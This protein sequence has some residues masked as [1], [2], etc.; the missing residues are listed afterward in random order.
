MRILVTGG[1]GFIG[2]L[3][4]GE[5]L[6]RGTWRT[7]PITEVV[8][9]DRVVRPL[10]RRSGVPVTSIEGDLFDRAREAFRQPVDVVVH[11]AAAVSSECEADLD[12]GLRTNIGGTWTVLEEARAQR[13]A[14]GPTATFV[15]ASSVAVYGSDPEQ[16]LPAVVTD[17]TLPVPRSSYGAQKLSCEHVLADY[18]RRGLVDARVVRLMTVAVRPG[19]PNAAAS[20]FVSSIIREPLAGRPAVCPVGPDVALALASPRA[21][22]EGILTVAEADRGTRRGELN[23]L[24]PVNLPALTA[25]VGE[26]LGA[27]RRVGGEDAAALVS[28]DLDPRVD[29]IVR[30][31]PARFTSTRAAALGLHPDPDVESLIRAYVDEHAPSRPA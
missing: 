19:A 11:L 16:P 8:I 7:E 25:T 28:T 22:V 20:S 10:A 26:L 30:S 3:V 18:T 1:H 17:S 2:S 13:E 27:L 6:R 23:G 14:G 21:T 5:L 4:V 12:L 31:W 15:F 9:V 24:L 29:A